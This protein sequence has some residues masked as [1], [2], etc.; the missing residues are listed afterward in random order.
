MAEVALFPHDAAPSQ[1]AAA[2]V[3]NGHSRA[4][5]CVAQAVYHESRGEPVAGQRAVA[6]VVMNRARRARSTPCAVVDAPGQFSGR[7]RW[8]VGRGADWD[9]AVTIARQS[10]S[11]VVHIS[12]SI[13]S[14]HAARLGRAFRM[15]VRMRI[16][17]HVFY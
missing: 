13:T 17:A 12:P 2:I 16:G 9:R 14:F 8:R 10:L 11:G 5:F 7:S 1:P 6:D 15:P 4:L 3:S